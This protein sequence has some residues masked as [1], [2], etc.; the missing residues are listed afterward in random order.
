MRFSLGTTFQLI[1]RRHMW[2]RRRRALLISAQLASD[3]EGSTYEVRFDP[4]IL[5]QQVCVHRRCDHGCGQCSLRDAARRSAL[6]RREKAGAITRRISRNRK[7]NIYTTRTHKHTHNH[8]RERD[9]RMD[10]CGSP[11]MPWSSALPTK[12]GDVECG[13]RSCK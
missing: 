2:S 12:D 3:Y 11:S 7:S 8:T 13:N 4:T 9:Q 1:L 5:E 10:Y 6:P